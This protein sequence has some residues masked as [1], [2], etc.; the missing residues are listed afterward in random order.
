MNLDHVY[1]NHFLMMLKYRDDLVIAESVALHEPKPT[2]AT[3]IW[4][5][6]YEKY[7][8]LKK[9]ISDH[10]KENFLEFEEDLEDFCDELEKIKYKLVVDC[11]L[12]NVKP[13]LE[14]IVRIFELVDIDMEIDED[15]YF[16]IK[17][18]LKRYAVY[19]DLISVE[20]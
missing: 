14:S 10:K 9:I 7:I 19:K 18:F 17:T 8:K 11:P 1:L 15:L 13:S 3:C 20:S 16:Y 5:K 6:N 12:G 4:F 2:N